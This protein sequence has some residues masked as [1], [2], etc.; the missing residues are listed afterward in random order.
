MAHQRNE[1]GGLYGIHNTHVEKC[2]FQ[3]VR[4][5]LRCLSSC[6]HRYTVTDRASEA[7]PSAIVRTEMHRDFAAK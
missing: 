5:S 2:V 4:V 7:G 6:D 3:W 1:K